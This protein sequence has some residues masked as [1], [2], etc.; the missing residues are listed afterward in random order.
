MIIAPP[1]VAI[2]RGVTHK[3]GGLGCPVGSWP[4]DNASEGVS[5]GLEPSVWLRRDR[6][7][8]ISFDLGLA[9]TLAR[10]LMIVTAAARVT[11]SQAA[12]AAISGLMPTMFMTRV[13]L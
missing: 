4:C 7:E 1:T 10:R 2:Y 11:A 13:M 5:G 8:Q 6:F 9:A 3:F 12:I